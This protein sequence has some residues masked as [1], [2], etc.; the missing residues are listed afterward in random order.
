MRFD[1][2]EHFKVNFNFKTVVFE[3]FIIIIHH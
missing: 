2:A 3:E 1:Q